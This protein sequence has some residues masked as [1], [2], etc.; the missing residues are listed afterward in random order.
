MFVF[1]IKLT[2]FVGVLLL[3][4]CRFF[5]VST[6]PSVLMF[7][8]GGVLFSVYVL[9]N[10]VNRQR[11]GVAPAGPEAVE[12]PEAVFGYRGQTAGA[13]LAAALGLLGETLAI[14][15]AAADV[16]DTAKG[17]LGKTL[18]ALLAAL[19]GAI[20]LAG[21]LRLFRG[22]ARAYRDHIAVSGLV[23]Y[24]ALRWDEIIRFEY[25]CVGVGGYAVWAYRL[26]SVDQTLQVEK[27]VVDADRFVELVRQKTGLSLHDERTDAKRRRSMAGV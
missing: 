14:L 23:K 2:Y 22:A 13:V 21:A 15:I 16:E 20:F 10:V 17:V 26:H 12:Q 6:L 3:L 27:E 25:S 4:L 1:F 24:G 7:T 18:V 8:V 11:V 19:G 9:L 5:H